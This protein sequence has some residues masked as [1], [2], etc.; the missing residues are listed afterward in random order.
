VFAVV[1]AFCSP[2]EVC[3][4]FDWAAEDVG[5]TGIMDIGPLSRSPVVPWWLHL[6]PE[7]RNPEFLDYR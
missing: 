1:H 4:W 2:E 5:A 3:G 6:Q 7:K